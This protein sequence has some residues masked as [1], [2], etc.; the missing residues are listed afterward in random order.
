[1]GLIDNLR[2]TLAEKESE[3]DSLQREVEAFRLVVEY[4]EQFPQEER[5]DYSSRSEVVEL[6]IQVLE[7]AG[8]PMHYRRELYP[9]MLQSG[10]NLAGRD[11]ARNFAAYLSGDT[12]RRFAPYGEGNWGLRR[13]SVNESKRQQLLDVERL[14]ERMETS[15]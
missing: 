4:Y 8:K 5:S 3:L 9:L 1:M 14:P 10:L 7:S 13:W 2:A 12:E 11:P 6:T 15:T